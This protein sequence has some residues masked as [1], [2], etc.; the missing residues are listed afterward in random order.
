MESNTFYGSK[1]NENSKSL[2]WSLFKSDEVSC[3]HQFP[4]EMHSSQFYFF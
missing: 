3:L 1:V 2:V 4:I